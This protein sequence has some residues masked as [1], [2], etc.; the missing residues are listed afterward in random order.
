MR[1]KTTVRVVNL[2]WKRSDHS[3]LTSLSLSDHNN[4]FG[5]VYLFCSLY[6]SIVGILLLHLTSDVIVLLYNFNII[7]CTCYDC[8]F[9]TQTKHRRD[10]DFENFSGS[11]EDV[12]VLLDNIPRFGGK[13]LPNPGRVL[14][15][16]YD[17]SFNFTIFPCS[18]YTLLLSSSTL[19]SLFSWR[20]LGF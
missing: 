6:P 9:S 13:D 10:D 11:D 12:P 3:L 5:E 1:V 4:T 2:K 8:S 20:T 14:P 18:F 16:S 7:L 17:S 19:G 15:R